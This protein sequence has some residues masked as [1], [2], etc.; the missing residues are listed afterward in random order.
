MYILQ[1][2][3]R[4]NSRQRIQQDRLFHFVSTFLHT[5]LQN[6]NNVDQSVSSHPRR[7]RPISKRK[8]TE[9]KSDWSATF[10]SMVNIS[11]I[12]MKKDDLSKS[13]VFNL[14]HRRSEPN[15]DSVICTLVFSSILNVSPGNS[16]D[17]V[18]LVILLLMSLSVAP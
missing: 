3:Y 15:D 11:W 8:L 7:C 12:Q 13:S 16:P 6:L 18:Q 10:Q 5:D 17:I 2:K 14:R 1:C 4:N 9:A